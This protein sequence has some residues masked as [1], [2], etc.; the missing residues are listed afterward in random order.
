VRD[1]QSVIG[2]E[3]REQFMKMTDGGMPNHVVACVAGGSNAMGIFAGFLDDT[4]VTLHGVEPLGKSGKLGEHAATLSFGT[5]GTI[6]GAKC[7]LLQNEDGSP[8]QVASIASGLAYPGVGPEIC[9][10]HDSGRAIFS[11]VNDEQAISAFYQLSRTEG[12]IPALESAHAIA[13]SMQLAARRPAREKIVVNLSGRGDKDVDFMTD[14]YGSYEGSD[15]P[16]V[17]D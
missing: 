17:G 10:L 14:K 2:Q 16:R 12:I 13:F 1:F 5:E 8:A 3:A 6:H 4:K 7:I 11:S 15:S 9:M